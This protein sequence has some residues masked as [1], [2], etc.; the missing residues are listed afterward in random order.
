[1]W[2]LE[3]QDGAG[4][5][6]GQEAAR[7]SGWSGEQ[8]WQ[9]GSLH[10]AD[11]GQ[12]SGLQGQHAT[13]TGSTDRAIHEPVSGGS[14]DVWVCVLWLPGTLPPEFSPASC[15]SAAPS[16]WQC[17]RESSGTPPVGTPPLESSGTPPVGTPPLESSGTHGAEW[18]GTGCLAALLLARL[19]DTLHTRLSGGFGRQQLRSAE[20]RAPWGLATRRVRG[21]KAQVDGRDESRAL[22]SQPPTLPPFVPTPTGSSLLP[23]PTSQPPR[24]L[25][26]F[27]LLGRVHRNAIAAD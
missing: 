19:A 4:G 3:Q 13:V 10:S 18:Q 23:E 2:G 14:S 17:G 26:I 11:A 22:F 5:W 1:M 27:R 12:Q 7:W 25:I 6:S 16:S 8:E 24:S 15:G 21:R 9:Q 20:T